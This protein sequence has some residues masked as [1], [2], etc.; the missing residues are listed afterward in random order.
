MAAYRCF[1]HSVQINDGVDALPN[2]PG[3]YIIMNRLNGRC[4]VGAS[5]NLRTRCLT[6]RSELRRG[7]SGNRLLRRDVVKCGAENF[8][9]FAPETVESLQE[10]E[11]RGGLEAMEMRWIVQFKSYDEQRGYNSMLAGCWTPGA[12]FRD[13]EL[14]LRRSGSYTLMETVDPYDPI[15]ARMLASWAPAET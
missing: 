12:R 13:R 14:K 9:I 11:Q 10:A 5:K 1:E 2:K 7:I 4:Y 15:D 8:F 3:V 6:H